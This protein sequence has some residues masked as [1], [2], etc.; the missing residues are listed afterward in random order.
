M[1]VS[2]S[3]LSFSPLMKKPCNQNVFF[4]ST[5]ELWM[6]LYQLGVRRNKENEELLNILVAVG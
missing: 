6:R 1:R 4:L 3:I 5:D 2:E